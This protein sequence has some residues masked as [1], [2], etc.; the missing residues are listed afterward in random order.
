MKLYVSSAVCETW[1]LRKPSTH[2]ANKLVR[3]KY[4]YH[5]ILLALLPHVCPGMLGLC[6]KSADD[7]TVALVL[8]AFASGLLKQQ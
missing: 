7:K 5:I 6:T 4:S 1:R 8:H 2:M 3:Q